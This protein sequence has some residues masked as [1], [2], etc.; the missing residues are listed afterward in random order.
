VR[1]KGKKT[2]QRDKGYLPWGTKDCLW[3]ERTQ[4]CSTG[5]WQFVKGKG[6]TP[7]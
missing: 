4:T 2:R 5:K 3:I 1:E 7:C 6:K